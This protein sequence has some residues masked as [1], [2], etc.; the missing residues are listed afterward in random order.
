MSSISKISIVTPSFNQGAFIEEALHSVRDQVHPPL[1]HIVIDGV[2]TDDTISILKKCSE[3]PGWQHLQ[4]ISEPDSGQTEA[5]N[6]GFRMATGEIVG[7]LNA[8]DRYRPGCFQTAADAFLSYPAVDV[9]Y[10]DYAYMDESGRV[11]RIRREIEFSRFILRHYY[12][13]Y[14]PTASTF[15]RRRVFDHGNWL[16]VNYDYVMDYEF[17]LRL[18]QQDYRF[19]HIP[20]LLAD[21]R[22]H[23]A[24]KSSSPAGPIKQREEGEQAARMYSPILSRVPPGLPL[25]VAR[26]GVRALAASLRYSEKLL[27]GYYFEQLRNPRPSA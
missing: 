19:Q 26:A 16:N 7:W 9:F 3:Q 5:L 1:E 27:R 13:L 20:E 6:K 4:W 10:G 24:S 18:S 22:W 14:I 23:P 11:Y 12:P 15:F 21:F 2:S 17:F 25:T 8:D